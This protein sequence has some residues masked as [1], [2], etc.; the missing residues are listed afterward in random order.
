VAGGGRGGGGGG[1]G[2]GGSY[3]TQN[4][5]LDVLYNFCLKHFLRYE[6]FCEI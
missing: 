2:G 4:T 3:L 5:C 1:G 6:E